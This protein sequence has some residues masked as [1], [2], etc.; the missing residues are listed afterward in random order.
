MCTPSNSPAGFGD[1]HGDQ[2]IGRPRPRSAAAVWAAVAPSPVRAVGPVVRH[3][4]STGSETTRP[5]MT[6][7]INRAADA[8]TGEAEHH[9][10][11]DC[12]QGGL[13]FRGQ[14]GHGAHD[15]PAVR[16]GRAAGSSSRRYP[17]HKESIDDTVGAIQAGGGQAVGVAADLTKED[18]VD[19]AVATAEQAFGSRPDIAVANVG[20]PEA[21][22]F[23]HR[24]QRRFR[25]CRP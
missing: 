1:G 15:S 19:R 16:S 12:W 20:G 7:I 25:R 17:E 9:G 8:W 4:A 24:D 2:A 3:D 22:R 18:D 14:H 23:P 13:R 6:R 21:G 10:S 11:W 5:T